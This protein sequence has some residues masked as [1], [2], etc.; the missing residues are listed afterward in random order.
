LIVQREAE[1]QA[2]KR[3]AVIAVITNVSITGDDRVCSVS[4]DVLAWRTTGDVVIPGEVGVRVAI[5]VGD[6]PCCNVSRQAS[7]KWDV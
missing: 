5:R 1:R 7:T 6:R 3:I 4:E 2:H